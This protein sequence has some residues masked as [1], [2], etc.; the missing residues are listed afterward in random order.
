MCD[1]CARECMCISNGAGHCNANAKCSLMK[2][3]TENQ[4]E[5]SSWHGKQYTEQ[6]RTQTHTHTYIL[7][8]QLFRISKEC[9]KH[10]LNTHWMSLVH[11][12]AFAHTCTG[13]HHITT[14]ELVSEFI[15]ARL[16]LFIQSTY[17]NLLII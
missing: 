11:F 4:S 7:H 2:M 1:L 9:L 5:I 16:K 6:A 14:R 3:K 17:M 13:S 10:R 12:S 8:M 15:R